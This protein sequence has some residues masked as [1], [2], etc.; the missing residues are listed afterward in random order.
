MNEDWSKTP[1]LNNINPA[2]LS[3]LNAFVKEAE[4]KTPNELLPFFMASMK[5]ADSNGISFD[6]SETDMILNVLKTRMSASDIKKIDTIR[7]LSKMIAARTK[8]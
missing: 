7:N 1:E 4:H 2:K 3:M 5:K 8:K 6:D